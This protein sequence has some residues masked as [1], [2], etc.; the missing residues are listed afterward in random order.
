MSTSIEKEPALEKF[1]SGYNCA[2]AVLYSACERL[3]FDKNMALRLSS[4]FGAGMA[5]SQEVCGAVTG[6]IMALGLKYGRGDGEEKSKTEE[7]YKRTR[8][9]MS[10]FGEKHGSV[11]CR[12]LIK[13]DLS[14]PEGQQY[15]KDNELLRKT[16]AVCVATAIDLVA[17]EV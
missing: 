5:R 16:C 4:G 13:C 7:T 9:F 15:F 1:L 11:L 2:Q 10:A 14:T 12:E 17:S 6:G 8:T 3:N